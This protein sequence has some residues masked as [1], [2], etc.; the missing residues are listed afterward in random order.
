MD[1]PALERARFS[2]RFLA[3]FAD[4]FLI[5]AGFYATIFALAAA[6]PSAATPSIARLLLL[7]WSLLFII[8]HAWFDSGGRRTLGKA[9]LGIKVFSVEGEAPT[10]GQGLGRSFG[11]MLSGLPLNLGFFWAL[12]GERR[13][14][15][16]KLA[17]TIVLETRPKGRFG[18]IMSLCAAWGLGAVF[19]LAWLWTF[20]GAPRFAQMK[21]LASA[22][23][24]VDSLARLEESHHKATGGYTPDVS[25]LL[26]GPGSEELLR[27]LAQVL[28]PESLRIEVGAA[29]YAI[30][31]RALD[32]RKTLIRLSGP[33]R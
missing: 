30:E 23:I 21:L 17:G 11:Y 14:W 19:T 3:Y 16:D 31:A 20:I 7:L 10:F 27:E 18:R 33:R 12:T 1:E 29:A 26:Q 9:L 22:R 5:M 32:E 25:V 15:H 24:A 13:A 4:V 8:Y 2:D 28:D 6:P